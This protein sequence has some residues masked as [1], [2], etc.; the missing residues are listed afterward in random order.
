MRMTRG[1]WKTVYLSTFNKPYKAYL[2]RPTDDL[3]LSCVAAYSGKSSFPKTA[4]IT[5]P[6]LGSFQDILGDR[7]PR[8]RRLWRVT[9]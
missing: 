7:F 3:F 9:N 1:R 5:L 8:R 6:L 4:G 2:F